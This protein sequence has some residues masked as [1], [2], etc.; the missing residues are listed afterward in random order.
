VEARPR[1]S[2]QARA[3]LWRRGVLVRQPSKGHAAQRLIYETLQR[4]PTQKTVWLNCSR[5]FGKS[6]LMLMIAVEHCLQVKRALV[7]YAAPQKSDA[8]EIATDLMDTVLEGCPRD[9]RPKYNR[10]RKEYVFPSTGAKL[11]FGGV[12]GDRA[13]FL[14]G[15]RATLIIVDEAGEM[16]DLAYV[17]KSILRPQLLTTKGRMLIA[18]TPARSPGHESTAEARRCQALGE[19]AYFLFTIH[20][21]P[22]LTPEQIAEE[23]E[24]QGGPES[25]SWRREYLCQFVTDSARAIV[26]EWT[27]ERALKLVEEVPAARFRDC[28][29]S[30]D[31]G[32]NRDLTVALGSWWDWKQRTLVFEWEWWA[33]NPDTESIA[34]GINAAIEL[35]WPGRRPFHVVSDIDHRFA[36]DLVRFGLHVENAQKDDRDA[37]IADFRTAVSNLKVKVHPRC[38][39]LI[40]TLH[41]GIWNK[42]RTDWERIEGIG[43]SD[44]LAAAIYGKR[45]VY[46]N[47]NPVPPHADA[48]WETHWLSPHQAP[49]MSEEAESLIEGLSG[50]FDHLE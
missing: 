49:R 45:A 18:S 27:D 1:T 22:L 5:R 28:Y 40:A 16:D 31:L 2:Q 32:G 47:R 10:N 3:K 6:T 20:D 24:L 33:K 17:L 34:K 21:N 13:K 44:A 35:H 30:I 29:V 26:P 36:N 48:H 11:R 14:R 8:E 39:L 41:Q 42:R 43:H 15:R 9:L 19:G 50:G 38:K 7:R 12:N 4:Y 46:E 23:C 37:G 25:D